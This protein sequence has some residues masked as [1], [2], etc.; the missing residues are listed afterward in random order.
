MITLA[1]VVSLSGS[2]LI[3]LSLTIAFGSSYSIIRVGLLDTMMGI[4]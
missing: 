2:G 1:R 4:G 3:K